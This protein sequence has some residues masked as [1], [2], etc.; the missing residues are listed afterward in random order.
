MEATGFDFE[1]AKGLIR[2]L[3]K[4]RNG[5]FAAEVD[6]AVTLQQGH[7]F[8]WAYVPATVTGVWDGGVKAWQLPGATTMFPINIARDSAGKVVWGAVDHAGVA[9]GGIACSTW[10]PQMAG[11]QTA[12]VVGAGFYLGQ[13]F[14]TAVANG[15]PMVLM[16]LP[17]AAGAGSS[18]GG[19]AVIEVVTDVI[20]T[21]SGI[22]VST[23]TLSGADYDNAVIRQF[24]ALSD[25]TQKSYVGNQ[26]RAVVVNASAT[27]LEFGAVI[28]E[29]A[30]TFIAL[31]DTPPAYGSGNTYKVLTVSSNNA[32]ISFSDNN[33]TTS[34]SIT[35]GGNPNDPVGWKTLQLLNDA[36][37]PSGHSFYGVDVD[38]VKGWR[39][40]RLTFLE[41]FPASY[42]ASGGYLLRVKADESGLEFA[43]N[44][45][46]TLSDCPGEYTGAA[47]KLLR[48]N[49]TETGVEFIGLDLSAV[50]ADITALQ[51]DVSTLQDEVAALQAGGG[52][53]LTTI[54][55]RLT[56]LEADSQDQWAAINSLNY[57][58]TNN[59]ETFAA[60]IAA[61]DARIAALGG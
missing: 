28:G 14:D 10:L 48:V 58:L 18:S 49:L 27:G 29:N 60:Q 56:A 35:G 24:T 8:V 23:V 4:S 17:P 30:D 16:A 61:L 50:T 20:C 47:G 51:A 11:T 21:P 26:G 7:R 53:D 54:N 31:N 46:I 43:G 38:S 52:G 37:T 42:A 34:N 55:N 32:G 2:L 3:K 44:D 1:T 22:E 33:I 13:V 5:E 36:K 40:I 12:P 9:S 41:D 25:V 19:N 15:N 45:F 59:S 39:R 57:T 6:D